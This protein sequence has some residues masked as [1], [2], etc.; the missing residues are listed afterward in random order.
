MVLTERRYGNDYLS[1]KNIIK[2]KRS[3]VQF[4]LKNKMMIFC[5]N[6]IIV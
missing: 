2:A 1:Y 4:S 5:T 6:G 3:A